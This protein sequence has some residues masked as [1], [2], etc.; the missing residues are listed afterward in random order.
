MST[1]KEMAAEYR[2][3]TAKLAVRL[4]EKR[5]AGV[6]ERELATLETMLR[7]MRVK[8]RVLESYYDAPRE[9]SITMSCAYAPKRS[10]GD[11]G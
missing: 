9:K 2:R 4:A 3:E 10:R 1:M 5:A 8:Q 11:D 7:E 6:P